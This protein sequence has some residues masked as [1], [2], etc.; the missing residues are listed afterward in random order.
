MF[1]IFHECVYKSIKNGVAICNGRYIWKQVEWT[2]FLGVIKEYLKYLYCL[3]VSKSNNIYIL[4]IS[5]YTE[6]MWKSLKVN[7]PKYY[8]YLI[9]WGRNSDRQIEERR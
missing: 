1:S 3:N 7:L 4:F 5:I 6:Y 2:R 9:F 8:D